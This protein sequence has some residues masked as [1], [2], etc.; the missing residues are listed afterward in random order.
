MLSTLLHNFIFTLPTRKFHCVFYAH[1]VKKKNVIWEHSEGICEVLK[2]HT[3]QLLKQN[4][5]D[6]ASLKSHQAGPHPLPLL[7]TASLGAGTRNHFRMFGS[8]PQGYSNS[9]SQV[10]TAGQAGGGLGAGYV[11]GG[12]TSLH[13]L[14]MGVSQK[15]K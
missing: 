6:L 3:W 11:E 8:V 9:I 5:K 14:V 10:R 1:I 13:H 2:Q 15:I 12:K 4:F 7:A